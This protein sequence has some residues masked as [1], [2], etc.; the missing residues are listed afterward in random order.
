GA[1][2]PAI[3]LS[4]VVFPEPFGPMMPSR[5]PS[6]RSK[7]TSLTARTPPN[8]FATRSTSSRGNG[9]LALRE[10]RR[11]IHDRRGRRLF[12]P[13]QLLLAVDPLHED[14]RDDAGAV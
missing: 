4:S 3:R 1:S 9:E 14:R 7:L 12:R 13:H 8:D 11:R 5:S 2:A 10:R 6:A